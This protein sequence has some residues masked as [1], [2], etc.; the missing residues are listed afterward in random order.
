MMN[1]EEVVTKVAEQKIAA[2]KS[3]EA[4]LKD[5]V[6][7]AKPKVELFIMSHCPYGTQMEK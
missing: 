7:S 3:K 2:E 4:E 1:I 6:K 5:L